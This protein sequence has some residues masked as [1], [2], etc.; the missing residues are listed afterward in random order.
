MGGEGGI[1]T[2][3]MGITEGAGGTGLTNGVG[4]LRDS[5]LGLGLLAGS[6][7]FGGLGLSGVHT[8]VGSTRQGTIAAGGTFASHTL[9]G[10]LAGG[11]WELLK[12][13]AEVRNFGSELVEGGHFGG[14]WILGQGWGDLGGE[15]VGL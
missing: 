3:P 14:F 7:L 4:V 1:H 13:E 6:W 10:G 15:N 9:A 11:R 8:A 5:L 2:V 12:L